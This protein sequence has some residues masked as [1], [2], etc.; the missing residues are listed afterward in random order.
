MKTEVSSSMGGLENIRLKTFRRI[1]PIA[2]LNCF[3]VE[4]VSNR[5]YYT[6]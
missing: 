3:V 1:K 5:L 4:S 2:M 6:K